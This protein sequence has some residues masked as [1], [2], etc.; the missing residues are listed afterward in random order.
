M[1]IAI[2]RRKIAVVSNRSFLNNGRNGVIAQSTT[3]GAMITVPAASA[4]HHVANVTTGLPKLVPLARI[5]PAIAAV[6]LI[7]AV[8]TREMIAN[9]AMPRG[10]AK[11]LRPSDQRMI[12]QTP[13]S[14]A[15]RTPKP[16]TPDSKNEP[17]AM[18]L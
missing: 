18:A 8:G 3:A 12:N 6:E 4:S 13:A 11:V 16:M 14:A 1:P 15:S 2:A 7:I 10:V 5:E 17:A 9:L